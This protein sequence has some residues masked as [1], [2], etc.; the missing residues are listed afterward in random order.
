MNAPANLRH[1]GVFTVDYDERLK[2]RVL[3]LVEGALDAYRDA[4]AARAAGDDA[5]ADVLCA[6]ADR[7]VC[8]ANETIEELATT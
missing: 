3:K 8:T 5:S 2:V 7:A 1:S 4:S 6:A